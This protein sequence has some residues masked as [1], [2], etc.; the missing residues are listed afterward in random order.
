MKRR[1]A[2]LGATGL[3]GRAVY[4]LFIN[5]GIDVE[6]CSKNGGEIKAYP[7]SQVDLYR[8]GT[9][10]K[11]LEN[12]DVDAIIYL[13]SKIPKTFL[14]AD[15]NLFFYNLMMH[16]HVLDYWKKH[17]CHLIYASSC[18][19]Y[20]HDSPRPLKE[21]KIAFSDN[22]YSISK[23]VGEA[24]FFQE[25]LNGLPLSILRI[26]APYGIDARRKTVINIFLERALTGKDL[27]IFGNGDEQQDF[28]YV[29]DVARAFR[30]AYLNKKYGIYNIAS[31]RTITMKELAN[32]VINLTNSSSR[33]IYS[34]K[35]KAQERPKVKIDVS[36]ALNELGFSSKYSL[37]DGLRKCIFQYRG[38]EL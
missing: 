22:Y 30:I 11:W 13:S 10:S 38:T 5:A 1:V 26:N 35:P 32:M 6:A 4:S 34:A 27:I 31:G 25:Y 18:S 8:N 33:I 21:E 14:E 9:L 23:L 37:E 19:I 29:L 17:K 24:L 2:I 28:I 12:K 36:K 3:I 20:G 15:W 16:K 7:V